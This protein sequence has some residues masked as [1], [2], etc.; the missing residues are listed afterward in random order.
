MKSVI[1]F[2]C[3][4]R[5]QLVTFQR[6]TLQC[7][8]NTISPFATCRFFKIQKRIELHAPRMHFS[9][10]QVSRR[11]QREYFLR[12]AKVL[13]QSPPPCGRPEP[14]AVSPTSHCGND[15]ARNSYIAWSNPYASVG[16]SRPLK[17]LS[18]VATNVREGTMWQK[19]EAP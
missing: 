17:V 7:F 5:R 6:D 8:L 11:A 12:S 9:V 1:G 15:L 18:V 2:V 4:G 19:N 13:P 16:E 14:T 3:Y 10:A